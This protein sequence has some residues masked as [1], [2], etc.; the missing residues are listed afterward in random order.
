[1]YLNHQVLRSYPRRGGGACRM[2]V[3]FD[4]LGYC[5]DMNGFITD[6]GFL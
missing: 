6:G 3:R 2:T 4:Y 1:M 5:E